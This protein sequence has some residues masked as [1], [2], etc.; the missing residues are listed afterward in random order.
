MYLCVYI[1][2]ICYICYI[3][4][5]RSFVFPSPRLHSLPSFLLLLPATFPSVLSSLI[6]LF[7]PS[8][9]KHTH[10]PTVVFPSFL[11]SFLPIA[12]A[13][14][15]SDLM[16]ASKTPMTE[17]EIA[18]VCAFVLK[19]EKEGRKEGRQMKEGK[20]PMTENKSLLSVPSS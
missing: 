8:S 19:G 20:M 12:R 18:I 16:S 9:P 1:L 3:P 17:K 5:F 14:S 7:L 11:P 4:S 15:V 10:F 6:P 2:Y 13:G